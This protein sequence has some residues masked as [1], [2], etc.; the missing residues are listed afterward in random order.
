MRVFVLFSLFAIPFLGRGQQHNLL[1]PDVA[2]QELAKAFHNKRERQVIYDKVIP[3][4]ATAIAVAEQMLF[5]LYGK[6]QIIKERPY[7]VYLIDGYWV[8]NGTLPKGMVGGTFLIILSEKDG[9]VVKLT[10]YK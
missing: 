7:E 3:D 6:D 4:K 9:R 8:L 5:R 1:G 2:R 10:H